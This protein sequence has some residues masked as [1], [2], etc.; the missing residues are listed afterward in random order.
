MCFPLRANLPRKA[1][2]AVS[3]KGN[4]RERASTE[5]PGVVALEEEG[6]RAFRA[7]GKL[8]RVRPRRADR[9][10]A[11]LV[12]VLPVELL[13]LHELLQRLVHTLSSLGREEKRQRHST[14]H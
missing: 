10:L 7:T 4:P 13:G 9:V 6:P 11:A 5:T 14:S 8:T 12:R 1:A 2:P 3:P